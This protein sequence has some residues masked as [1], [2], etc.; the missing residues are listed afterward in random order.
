MKPDINLSLNPSYFCSLRCE[1][2]YLSPQQL[3][4]KTRLSLDRLGELLEEVS[5]YFTIRHVDLYGGEPTLLPFDYVMGLKNLLTPYVEEVN[6]NTNLVTVPKWLEDEFFYP[7]VSYDFTAREKHEE[8]FLNMLSLNRDFSILTLATPKVMSL[9]MGYIM[10]ILSVLKRLNTWEIKP[11]SSNQYNDLGV[12]Y[13][14]H[15]DFVLRALRACKEEGIH[16]T[17]RDL[18][19]GVLSGA[20]HAF[21]DDHLYITPEGR[22][23]VLEFDKN[24][25]EYFLN[26]NNVSDYIAWSEQEKMKVWSNPHC[27]QCHYVGKCLTEHYREVKS[28]DNS[29]NG[30]IR[31]IEVYKETE[32]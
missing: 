6:V 12:S 11:Y 14:Q 28:L 24:D 13:T 5:Q 17:N 15:E 10:G 22:Y 18:L 27:S 21:S 7:S 32:T 23:A 30:F 16:L 2:C 19:E 26:L 1:F 8:V 20:G 4:D 25:K 3:G 9:E 29:C 31:L